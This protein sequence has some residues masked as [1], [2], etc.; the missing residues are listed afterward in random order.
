MVICRSCFRQPA[1]QICN[2]LTKA[3]TFQGQLPYVRGLQDDLPVMPVMS[4]VLELPGFWL[5]NPATGIDAVQL[6]QDK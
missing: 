6:V 3:P 2:N 5:S 1:K 4:N